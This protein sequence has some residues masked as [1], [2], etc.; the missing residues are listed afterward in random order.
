VKVKITKG[1][2]VSLKTFMMPSINKTVSVLGRG[3][4]TC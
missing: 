4:L 3:G 2:K 1:I